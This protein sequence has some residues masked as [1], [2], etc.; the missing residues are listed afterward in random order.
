MT[1]R[2]RAMLLLMRRFGKIVVADIDDLICDPG[3]AGWNPGVMN[4]QVA[5][6]SIRRL[7][8]S[9]RNALERFARITVSTEPLAREVRT[10]F[11][12]ASVCVLPNAVFREWREEAESFRPEV[13]RVTY[14]CGT[15]SHDRD[16]AVAEPGIEAFLA[17]NPAARMEVT[18]PLRHSLRAREGQVIQRTKVPFAEYAPLFRGAWVNLAPLEDTP[19]TR[20]KSALKVLEA[21]FWGVPTIC[22]PNPDMERYAEAGALTVR[23]GADWSAPLERLMDP[24][25]YGAVAEG[26]RER[27]L[28]LAD[29]DAAAERFLGFIARPG[30][31]R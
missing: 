25:V 8:A 10:R 27:V 5:P 3:M 14:F 2:L 31:A 16:F 13:G 22:S 7:Y 26:L 11:P 20:C 9:H 6:E 1:I 17:A 24:G 4:G 29:V 15:R 19:F 30:A 21:G 28:A 23:T 12:N 18:G